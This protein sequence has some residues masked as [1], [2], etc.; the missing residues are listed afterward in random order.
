[1][2]FKHLLAKSLPEQGD[3]QRKAQKAASYTGHIVAVMQSA[4]AVGATKKL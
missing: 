2:K 4:D 3:R 1:M